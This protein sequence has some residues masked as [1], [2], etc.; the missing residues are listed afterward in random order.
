MPAIARSPMMPPRLPIPDEP[1]S[2][3]PGE[4][5][6]AFALPHADGVHVVEHARIVWE[7]AP[8][9]ASPARDTNPPGCCPPGC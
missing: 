5:N 4:Q 8:P 7:G 1:I 6:V 9:P 2:V 3:L